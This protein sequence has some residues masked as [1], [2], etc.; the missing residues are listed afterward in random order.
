ME[1]IKPGTKIDFMGRRTLFIAISS[2]L[3]LLSLVIIGIKGFDMGV[4][5]KGGTKVI[6]SFKSSAKVDR[7][8][9][10]SV[11]NDF[12]RA[13]LKGKKAV[14]VEVQDFDVGGGNSSDTEKFQILTELPS[15]LSPMDR[16]DLAVA[17]RK[18][19][20]KGTIVDT[21]E[22]GGDKFYVTL[23]VKWPLSAAKKEITKVF[24]KAGYKE[25]DIRSDQ[26]ER[27]RMD[28]AREKDILSSAKT[29][30][31]E[32]E[33][34]RVEK[35]AKKKIATLSDTRFTVQV[36]EIRGQFARVLRQH[37]KDAFVGVI[38]AASVSP[39]VGR[40]L[41]ENGLLAMLYAIIG[42]LIYVALR[43]DSRFAPGAVIALIHD[44][45]ISLGFV[46]L[47]DIKFTLPIIAAIMTLIGYSINDTIVVYD[48][49]RENL[50]KGRIGKLLEVINLSVN[51]TLSRTLLTSGTTLLTVL[52]IYIF[53]G[54]TIKDFALVLLFG[55]TIGTYSSVFI[56]SPITWY[57][58]R[59]LSKRKTAS[60]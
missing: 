56:A 29:P 55:I 2:T 58:D 22:A 26:E 45:T 20:G 1:I 12:V 25:L 43:F 7:K 39:K 21:S 42:I 38:S 40:Q 3:V 53:G 6:V 54:G 30:E 60:A 13:Q 59:Y 41:F 49:I 11:I 33:L 32:Q 57:L 47:V 27:I 48:R 15:F 17:I 24:A 37:F 31:T 23:P 10:R 5:F 9:I 36:Q 16:L 19:F 4:D 35:D 14:Q 46:A 28:V 50:N 51:E 18:H 52:S 8:K 44:A 34:L